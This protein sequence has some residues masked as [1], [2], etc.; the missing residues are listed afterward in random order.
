M[1]NE[2]YISLR[3]FLYERERNLECECK[4]EELEPIWF[5][6]KKNVKRILHQLMNRKC[7]IYIPGRGRGNI[8]KIIFSRPFKEEIDEYLQQCINQGNLEEVVQMM[9]SPIPKSWLVDATGKIHKMLGLHTDTNEKDILHALKTREITTLDPLRVKIAFETHLIQHLGDTLIRYDEKSDRII[10]HLAHHYKADHDYRAWTFFIRKGVAF[11]DQSEM[12][13]KDIF[14]TINRIKGDSQNYSWLVDDIERVNCLGT[15]KITIHLKRS[16]P[17]FIRYLAAPTFCILPAHLNFTEQEWI[18]TGPFMLGEKTQNKLILKANNHYFKERPLIDEIHIHHIS[19][20]AAETIYFTVDKNEQTTKTSYHS[21][22]DSGFQFL[23][24]NF[25]RPL[26]QKIAF[27]EALFHVFDVQK[28]IVELHLEAKESSSFNIGRSK[29]Q[30]RDV[31]K[32]PQLLNQSEY[33]GEEL[34]LFH[35]AND[36]AINA[37]CWLKKEANH[38]GVNIKLYEASYEAFYESDVLEEADL[39]FM[40]LSLFSDKHLAFLSGF[41]NKALIFNQVFPEEAEQ[42]IEAEL[43]KFEH[44]NQLDEREK[45]MEKIE[46]YIR[47][48]YISLFLYHPIVNRPLD[49]IIRDVIPHSFGHLDFTKLWIEQ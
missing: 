37:A 36:Y 28:M 5:C 40:G 47:A 39:L 29:Q 35:F 30:I 16:N 6:T 4:I 17:F 23:S 44:S 18:G 22:D 2:R 41:R 46:A 25:N 45:M 15:Y 21:I 19:K 38:F 43:F 12:T 1:M 9:R 26:L 7:L 11:H 34:V 3:T 33:T 8:S 32:I 49:S 42:F 10:P 13:S 48:N 27:R 24:F 14:F 20:D 31:T